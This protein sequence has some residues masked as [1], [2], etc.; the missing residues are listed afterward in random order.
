MLGRK[1]EGGVL[2]LPPLDALCIFIVAFRTYYPVSIKENINQHFSNCILFLGIHCSIFDTTYSPH[3]VQFIKKKKWK[4]CL[5][6]GVT[7]IQSWN[8]LT[9]WFRFKSPEEYKAFSVCCIKY[10]IH[11]KNMGNLRLASIYLCSDFRSTTQL[12]CLYVRLLYEHLKKW[13]IDCEHTK[14]CDCEQAINHIVLLE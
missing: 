12:N 13:Y 2:T 7:I 3:G 10:Q 6:S 11:N 1:R 5:T 14:S 9:M 4:V 8:F